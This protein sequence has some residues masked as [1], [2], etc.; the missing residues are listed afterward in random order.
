MQHAPTR[1]IQS[2]SG[3]IFNKY[4]FTRYL[5]LM[6]RGVLHTPWNVSGGSIICPW[7]WEFV[8]RMQYAPTRIIQSLP[9]IGFNKYVFIRY[10]SRIG[11]GVL[12]TPQHVPG[13][14]I[15]YPWLWAFVGRMQYAPTRTIQYFPRTGFNK[16]VFIKHLSHIDMGI[17]HTSRNVSGGLIICSW[18]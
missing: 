15:I 3:I 4:V 17:L 12:Y 14:L 5:F 11:S 16:Y 6:G 13:E 10:L 9:G 1:T 18:L 7:P 2:L 8:R